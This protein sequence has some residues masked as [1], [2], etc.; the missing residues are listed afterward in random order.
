[1]ENPLPWHNGDA[2]LY[3]VRD[4]VTA[5]AGEAGADGLR[6]ADAAADSGGRDRAAAGT[7]PEAG[8]AKAPR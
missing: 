1:M 8:D 7:T 4:G 6:G 3:A 2:L 5:R